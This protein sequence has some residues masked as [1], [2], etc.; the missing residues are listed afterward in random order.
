MKPMKLALV[1][2]LCLAGC[3]GNPFG[4]GDGTPPNG[5]GPPGVVG[6][7]N[8]AAS[9]ALERREAKVTA[10]GQDYGNGFAEGYVY[11]PT[12][13]TFGVDGLAFDGANVYTR[14]TAVPNLG[15]ATAATGPFQVYEGANTFNDSVT[16]V[17]INQFFHRAVQGVSVNGNTRFAIVR[18]G[19]YVPFG[20]GGFL[21]ERNG[22]V[23]LPSTGQATY[24]GA[25]GGLR[26][27]DGTGGIEYVT[28]NMTVD[29]DFEDFNDGETPLGDG[30][31]G[32]VTGR[33]IIDIFGTD[34]TNSIVGAI[35]ADLPPGATPL[36][37]LPILQFEVGPGVLSETG[38][39]AGDA[40]ST[41]FDG[42][43]VT[44]YEA[45]KYFAIISDT[46]TVNAG[47]IVGVI[48][49]KGDDPRLD[50]VTFRETGGFI[51]YRP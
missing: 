16:G 19:S 27:F 43:T 4:T 24:S 37:E 47:E 15:T 8:P 36:T 29:I 20:F 39:V 17:P 41:F 7:E 34:I 2:M 5:E 6:T 22:R 49:V 3:G 12:N 9:R 33:R 14:S 46:S 44:E 10:P 45:G 23:T 35:N 48:V 50:G 21:Y 32:E 42:T 11:D 31:K 38:E 1:A 40:S 13:D 51:L 28:G 18:T 25:Y 26:D 30:I